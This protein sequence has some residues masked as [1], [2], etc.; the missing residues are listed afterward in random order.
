MDINA[1]LSQMKMLND[2]DIVK[3]MNAGSIPAWA[4][5]GELNQ[6]KQMKGMAAIQNPDSVLEEALPKKMADGGLV[7]P[8]MMNPMIFDGIKEM[9]ARNSG[10]EDP[11]TWESNVLEALYN[12]AVESGDSETARKILQQLRPT[13]ER[14]RFKSS[15]ESEVLRRDYDPSKDNRPASGPSSRP[16]PP[17]KE[18]APYVGA[19]SFFGQEGEDPRFNGGSALAREASGWGIPTP[20][21]IAP[22]NPLAD[23]RPANGPS[24]RNPLDLTG[25]PPNMVRP[26]VLGGFPAATPPTISPGPISPN[27]DYVPRV[28][29]NDPRF[30]GGSALLRELEPTPDDSRFE[31]GVESGLKWLGG[32]LDPRGKVEFDPNIGIPGIYKWL[33]EKPYRGNRIYPDVMQPQGAMPTPPAPPRAFPDVVQPQGQMPAS[34]VPA[35]PV[36]AP[37][38]TSV[39]PNPPASHEAWLQQQLAQPVDDG[40]MSEFMKMIQS[41]MP[42]P[43]DNSAILADMKAQAAAGKD[44]SKMLA[45]LAFGSGMAGAPGSFSMGVGAGGQAM[46]PVAQQG[47]RDYQAALQ[48]IA[49]ESMADN[50]SNVDLQ[51]R[52]LNSAIAATNTGIGLRNAADDRA[53]R[54]TSTLLEGRKLDELSKTREANIDIAKIRANRSGVNSMKFKEMVD[55]ADRAAKA[56]MG[57]GIDYADDASRNEAYNKFFAMEMEKMLRLAQISPGEE[58]DQ[59]IDVRD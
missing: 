55:Q 23:M 56:A 5:I 32:Q 31:R 19:D 50:R 9:I 26:S 7:S 43:V 53:Y 29:P 41:N 3:S 8:A 38:Q 33:T 39:A 51:S 12:K 4:G 46:T 11:A 25:P 49:K 1:I 6:R 10:G 20:Q 18:A 24:T 45:L 48:D 17:R 44:E 59:A 34:P 2:E 58:D 16:T 52:N 36:T 22:Y 54:R 15:P 57:D 37:A 35:S 42:Q 21:S 13:Y 30:N 28:D 27:M 40:G 14:P 47:M